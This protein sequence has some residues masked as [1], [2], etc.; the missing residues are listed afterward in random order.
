M[1]TIGV[2]APAS[3]PADC[4]LIG[5]S[6]SDI[7]AAHA[8]GARAIGYANKPGKFEKLTNAGADTVA[9]QLELITSEL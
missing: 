8:F 1:S 3:S 9:E 5:D 6:P 2:P 7:K 4:T